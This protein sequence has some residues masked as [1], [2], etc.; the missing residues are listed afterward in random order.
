MINAPVRSTFGSSALFATQHFGFVLQ[1]RR[2]SPS[3]ETEPRFCVLRILCVMYMYLCS[4]SQE[5]GACPFPAH[6]ATQKHCFASGCWGW[7]PPLPASLFLQAVSHPNLI[8]NMDRP[9]QI[10]NFIK[11]HTNSHKWSRVRACSYRD[12]GSARYTAPAQGST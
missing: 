5:G 10:V 6:L 7:G 1:G 2:A 11:R 4:G 3:R 12:F 9:T 8:W